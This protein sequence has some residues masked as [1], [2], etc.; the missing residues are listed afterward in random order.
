[1]SGL[2]EEEI[3][4]LDLDDFSANDLLELLI[5]GFTGP[6]VSTQAVENEDSPQDVYPFDGLESLD[7]DGLEALA[8][9]DDAPIVNA[10]RYRIS[11]NG[12]EYTLLLPS[13]AIDKV[14]I[15]ENGY[16]W[17]VSTSNISGRVF[18]GSF[19]PTD[20][21][22]RILYLGPC[23]GN[24]FANN[25]NYGSPNYVRRYYWSNGR[26]T[27]DDSYGVVTVL[28]SGYPFYQSQTLYYI[29]IVILGGILICLWRKSLH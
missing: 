4:G 28:D 16:L 17:N 15:D 27:Y 29:I 6:G 5:S 19:S 23:L 25:R 1:M 26:L 13:D 8:V 3:D 21:D 18:S 20:D 14:F 24:N 7:A 2:D 22:G 12:V 9:S 10:V 11:F